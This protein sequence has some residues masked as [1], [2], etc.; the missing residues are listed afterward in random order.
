MF[1]TTRWSVLLAG[2]DDPQAARLAL[3]HLCQA[4]WRPVLS[5]VRR[6]GYA[7][8][9]AEDL[10]QAFFTSMIERRVDSRADP[11][12]GRFRTLLLTALKHYLHN[13]EA[14]RRAERR[15]GGAR[16]EDLDGV[17]PT[18][19]QGEAPEQVFMR[20]WAVTVLDRAM[21]SLQAETRKAG[22]GEL[23]DALREF[24][25]EPPGAEDYARLAAAHGLRANTLAVAVHRLRQKLRQH[26]RAELAET[27]GS[28]ADLDAEME[29]L[30]DALGGVARAPA[31]PGGAAAD[32]KL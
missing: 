28:E 13:A 26:V 14:A 24:L 11:Q 29:V 25:I 8:D 5:Y 3:E 27:V 17:E 19:E 16:H 12:R 10:T 15:G 21:L 4:Y 2:R 20:Q 18:A 7:R 23:F 6:M 22:K 32:G 30:R 31:R 9:E 1:Q